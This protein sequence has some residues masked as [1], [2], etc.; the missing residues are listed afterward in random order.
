MPEDAD[1]IVFG[2][3]LTLPLAELFW[4]FCRSSGPGGQN[5]NKLSTKAVLEWPVASSPSLPDDVR[6][7]FL[8]RYGSR[9][10]ARGT[11]VLASQRTRSQQ[12]NRL[13]LLERLR[14]MLEAVA[15]PPPRRHPSKPSRASRARRLAAK[16]RR[17]QTKQGRRPIEHEP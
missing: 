13:D 12:Q 3:G 14:K 8:A 4:S 11:L 1:F 2:K 17:A 7:R 9:I 5:V 15:A 6:Q 10:N 16:R